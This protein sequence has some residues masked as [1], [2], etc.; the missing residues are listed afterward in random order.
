MSQNPRKFQ[1]RLGLKAGSAVYAS[2]AMNSRLF[3]H[4]P[5]S[6]LKISVA[7]QL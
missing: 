5:S 7:L 2:F 4:E 1:Q 6:V 3:S